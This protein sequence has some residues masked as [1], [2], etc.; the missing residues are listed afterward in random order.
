MMRAEVTIWSQKEGWVLYS[1]RPF[2]PRYG[3]YGISY[4]S[5]WFRLPY[6]SERDSRP[7]LVWERSEPV[8][9][10]KGSRWLHWKHGSAEYWGLSR[11][12]NVE[13]LVLEAVQGILGAELERKLRFSPRWLLFQELEKGNMGL[14]WVSLSLLR[15]RLRI[16]PDP[17]AGFRIRLFLGKEPWPEGVRPLDLALERFPELWLS[18]V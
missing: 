2:G 12:E 10:R 4:L 11:E 14:E 5:A 16:E 6:P 8:R 13:Q 9:F 1:T 18:L 7:V 17:E 15:P 3:G